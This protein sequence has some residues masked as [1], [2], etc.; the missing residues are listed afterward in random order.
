MPRVELHRHA[1]AR[2]EAAV[3][4]DV[5]AEA[6]VDKGA[7]GGVGGARCWAGGGVGRLERDALPVGQP[8]VDLLL[9]V[10]W[11]RRVAAWA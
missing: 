11:W 1:H 10:V 5:F 7:A 3:E 2:P 6:D 8:L 4:P 9:V